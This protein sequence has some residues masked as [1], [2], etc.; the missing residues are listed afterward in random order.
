M[1]LSL[2]GSHLHSNANWKPLMRNSG[3]PLTICEL[4]PPLKIKDLV[5]TLARGLVVPPLTVGGNTIEQVVSFKLFGVT[6][7]S[8]LSWA[9]HIKT[10]LKKS[11]T[12]GCSCCRMQIKHA[13]L[14]PRELLA[15]PTNLSSDPCLNMPALSG[16]APSRTIS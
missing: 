1:L 15:R 5:C 6:V 11:A 14:Q 12:S 13:G 7:T 9:F 4:T 3:L 2:Q 10:V 8:P 16:S